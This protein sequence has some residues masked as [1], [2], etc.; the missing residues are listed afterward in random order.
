[1]DCRHVLQALL[2][3]LPIAV[4]LLLGLVEVAAVSGQCRLLVCDDCV[5]RGP[6]E[7]TY[8]FWRGSIIASGGRA[9]MGGRDVA[10]LV[11]RRRVRCTQTD[12]CPRTEPLLACQSMHA[13]SSQNRRVMLTVHVDLALLHEPAQ[14]S[15]P[16]RGVDLLHVGG[17]RVE[18]ACRV[19]GS[20]EGGRGPRGC[21]GCWQWGA[22]PGAAEK[23]LQAAADGIG[24]LWLC[25]RP[26]PRGR[27]ISGPAWAGP[28]L[29][30]VGRRD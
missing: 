24:G 17:S 6:R 4:Q 14:L 25:S 3:Q 19:E 22:G 9:P 5:S 7:A 21:I 10:D 27:A 18:D 26:A 29:R 20:G 16:G 30:Q 1:L 11:V 23:H 15:E 28:L 8:E 13:G 12:G 2:Q